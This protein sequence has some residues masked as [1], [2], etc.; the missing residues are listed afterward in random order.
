[1]NET[2]RFILSTL[3]I[4]AGIGFLA[5]TLGS[6]LALITLFDL[7]ALSLTI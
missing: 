5:V 2:I 6:I 4:A 3:L 1:M 7:V